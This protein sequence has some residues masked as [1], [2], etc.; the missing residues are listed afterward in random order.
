MCGI[1]L[2]FRHAKKTKNKNSNTEKIRPRVI[3]E[4]YS[5]IS[6]QITE[7]NTAD[8]D[9]TYEVIKDF[10]HYD[11]PDINFTDDFL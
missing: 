9:P 7:N 5:R 3:P 10:N 6:I 4:T 2:W 8:N 11:E 1:V